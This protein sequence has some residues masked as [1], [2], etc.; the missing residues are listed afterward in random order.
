M[1]HAKITGGGRLRSF[2]NKARETAR[3]G[4]PLI[5]VGFRGD[6]FITIVAG[7]LE[8][9]N[10][11]TSLPERPAFRNAV[12]TIRDQL[13]RMI[14][15]MKATSGRDALLSL[16]DAEAK[17]IALWARD[18]LREG[19]L[20]F[21]GAELSER[22]ERRKLGTPGAGRQL[23]GAEGPKLIDHIHAWIDGQRV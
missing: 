6:R 11:R 9:G 19:Y 4:G 15:N 20:S 21:E 22:Q 10:P 1:A 3:R 14:R 7:Q 13:P 16:T 17:R 18:I 8:F 23:V 2:G 5:E 12:D